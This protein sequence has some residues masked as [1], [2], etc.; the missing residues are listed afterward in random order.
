MARSGSK[1]ATGI[2]SSP[3]LVLQHAGVRVDAGGDL[4]QAESGG[5]HEQQPTLVVDVV[6]QPGALRQDLRLAD[7]PVIDAEPVLSRLLVPPLLLRL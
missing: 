1:S 6:A 5:V 7:D 3:S 2:G 4:A